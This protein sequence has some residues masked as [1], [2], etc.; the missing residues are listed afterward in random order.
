MFEWELDELDEEINARID[1][2]YAGVY[3]EWP[4]PKSSEWT[5]GWADMHDGV[6]GGDA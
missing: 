3:R 6:R 2:M 4:E 5:M 1:E